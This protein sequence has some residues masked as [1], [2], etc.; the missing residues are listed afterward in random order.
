MASIDG[1]LPPDATDDGCLP[2]SLPPE[3]VPGY[4]NPGM[5]YFSR[6]T[7]GPRRMVTYAFKSGKLT[8]K[9]GRRIVTLA[10][11]R[12]GPLPARDKARKR[13]TRSKRTSCLYSVPGKEVT[14]GSWVDLS[15]NSSTTEPL[16]VERSS[17]SIYL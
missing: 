8:M 9:A 17:R 10:C 11:D 2:P 16:Y 3:Y 13:R 4:K 12:S 1:H 7:P 14:D 15:P 5:P 6:L